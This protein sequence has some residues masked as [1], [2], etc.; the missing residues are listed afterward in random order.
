MIYPSLV[1]FHTQFCEILRGSIG[2]YQVYWVSV[3]T[4]Q[5]WNPAIS[6]CFIWIQLHFSV[7][8]FFQKHRGLVCIILRRKQSTNSIKQEKKQKRKKKA[9]KGWKT[10]TVNCKTDIHLTNDLY[11][12]CVSWINGNSFYNPSSPISFCSGLWALYWNRLRLTNLLRF[13]T[14]L[15][16][17]VLS[18]LSMQHPWS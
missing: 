4:K 11:C 6:Y 10:L 14:L 12:I 1:L 18:V 3:C 15:G 5:M 16:C 17:P 2:F 8:F 9:K 7:L 13:D